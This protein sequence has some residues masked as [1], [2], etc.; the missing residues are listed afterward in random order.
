[1]F[2]IESG[3][4]SN[5]APNAGLAIAH[6]GNGG[7]ATPAPLRERPQQFAAI[8][9]AF[10]APVRGGPR[11]SA[12][13]RPRPSGRVV[14]GPMSIVELARWQWSD[15][16]AYHCNRTNL[17]IHLVAVP[18]FWIGLVASAVAIWNLSLVQLAIGILCLPLAI[19]LQGFG[20]KRE[21][22]PPV[23]FSSRSNALA[24]IV[25]EQLFTF[26]RYVLTGRILQREAQQQDLARP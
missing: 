3:R 14:E 23:P 26:P 24:R 22:V 10:V 11:A 7:A 1:V 6:R 8:E 9:M 18:L 17:A 15:Y 19:A 20:H 16:A 2:G 25:T 13:N 4:A 21:A 5:V 12:D